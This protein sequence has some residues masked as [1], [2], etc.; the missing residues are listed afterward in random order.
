MPSLHLF[1]H[2]M[3]ASLR[4]LPFTA[5]DLPWL[6]AA[7]AVILHLPTLANGIVWDDRAAL[8][9]NPDGQ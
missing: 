2:E 9:M 3:E 5:D 6:S 7:V 8:L 1:L 4:S